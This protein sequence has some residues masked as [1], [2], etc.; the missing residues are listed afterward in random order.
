[1]FDN[2]NAE[3]I[4]LVVRTAFDNGAMLDDR[5][6]QLEL[7]PGEDWETQVNRTDYANGD[8]TYSQVIGL[9]VVRDA[10]E[11]AHLLRADDAEAWEAE[12]VSIEALT[13]Q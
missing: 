8:V 10:P 1:V 7:R 11:C 9:L 6:H 2:A 12:A 5:W 4:F 3:P 13:C